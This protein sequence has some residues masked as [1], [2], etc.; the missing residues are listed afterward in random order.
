MTTKTKAIVPVHLYGQ[1]ADMD[2]I[3]TFAREYGLRVIEDCAQSHGARDAGRVAGTM[4]DA[5][6]YSFYPTKNLGAV[7]DAGMV[8]TNDGAIAERVKWLRNYGQTDRAHHELKGDNGRLDELQAA[9]LSVKLGY[10]ERWTARRR[11]I[12]QA[13]AA[14]LV[15]TP[16]GCPTEAANRFHVYHLYV[17]RVSDRG[18]FQEALARQGIETLV[19]Y[20]VPV[21]RQPAYSELLRDDHALEVTNRMAS[22]IVSLPM[23]PELED[24]EV[25][26][27]I[28][29]VQE[30][31]ASTR[32]A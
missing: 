21:H 17:V 12:A 18:A 30:W 4:G 19:H 1:C 8:V 2:P 9:V 24:S 20:P 23:Y 31:A 25:E 32:D 28:T 26:Q 27:I 5:G 16:I 13:Y 7:G 14:G 3:L 6:C 29:A 11:A 22:E 10:L 15:E